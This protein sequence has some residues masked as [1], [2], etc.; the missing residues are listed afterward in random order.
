MI[1]PKLLCAALAAVAATATYMRFLRP[2]VLD[3]GATP[4]EK[5]RPMPGDEIIPDA[6]PQT[7]RAISIEAP[8]DCIWPW[9]AQMG[10][11]PRGGAYTYDWIENLFGLNMHSVDRVLTEFQHLEAGDVIGDKKPLG[12]AV[13]LVEP[14]WYLVLEWPRTSA[15]WTFG[16]Y[17]ERDGRT[18]LVSRNRLRGSGPLFHLFMLAFM[19]PG[20][21]VM[22]RKMLFGIKQRAERL[23]SNKEQ[24]V[25]VE[26]A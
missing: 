16:L 3:W 18:R 4:A 15:T 21:L 22:E 7:T 10:P 12:L 1:T 13:R 11:R 5:A 6:A 2:G 14:G 8:Q 25:L 23:Y 24:R 17:P 9:L 19:E 26:A 20:S